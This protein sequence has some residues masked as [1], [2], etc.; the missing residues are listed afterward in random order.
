MGKLKM[1]S[2]SIEL[3]PKSSQTHN[4]L[5]SALA[6]KGNM[7]E[8]LAEFQKA[9]ELNPDNA[10]AHVNLGNALAAKGGLLHQAI[11][12]LSKGVDLA[13]GAANGQNGLGVALARAG[14][15]DEAAF[16]MEKAVNLTPQ[17][18][19]YHYNYGR[20]L[21]AKGALPEAAAQFEQAARLSKM[22]EPAILEMLAATYSDTGRFS[23][24]VDTARKALELVA[25]QHDD[26]LA[27]RLRA[28]LARYEGL[29]QNGQARS[30]T[31]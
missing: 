29:A 8:A 5:G 31:R 11:D 3:N 9:V 17:S 16:H 26:A 22:Q 10:A 24:A 25:Q 12:E 7:D 4:N 18:V 28:S 15:L 21:A 23:E 14:R 1:Q 20:V 30:T 6:E 19:D 2:W 27:A 13:P